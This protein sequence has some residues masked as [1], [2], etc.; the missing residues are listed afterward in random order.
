V[1]DFPGLDSEYH[2]AGFSQ[3]I[4]REVVSAIERTPELATFGYLRDSGPGDEGPTDFFEQFGRPRIEIG[5]EVLNLHDVQAV[6]EQLESVDT[7][8]VSGEG[9]Y[10]QRKVLDIQFSVDGTYRMFDKTTG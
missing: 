5:N 6:Q 2:V 10:L 7:R 1:L 3:L 9:R 4:A 8:M